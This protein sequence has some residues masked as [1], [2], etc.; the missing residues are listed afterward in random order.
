MKLTGKLLLVIIVFSLFI[1]NS[2][3]AALI[4]SGSETATNFN[5]FLETGG[6]IAYNITATP[7]SIMTTVVRILLSVLGIIFLIIILIAG[8]AWMRANGNEEKIQKA[9]DTLKNTLI[10][11]VLVLIAY[12]L[13]ADLGQIL[14][15]I[16]LKAN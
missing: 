15:T 3:S 7:E 11:L 8:S 9:K 6:K 10:G 16:F 4:N 5:T 14:A 13:S 12:A 2:A 1:F